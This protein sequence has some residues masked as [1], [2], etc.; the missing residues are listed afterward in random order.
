VCFILEFKD[1]AMPARIKKRGR[2]KGAEKTVIGLPKMKK[3][4]E[5]PLPFLKKLPVD[6]ERGIILICS[7]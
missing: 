7:S 5:N 4:S 3:R 1:V 6:K 2:P